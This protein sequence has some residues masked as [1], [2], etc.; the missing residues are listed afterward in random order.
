MLPR[1]VDSIPSFYIIPFRFQQKK[2]HPEKAKQSEAAK[3][4]LC[5]GGWGPSDGGKSPAKQHSAPLQAVGYAAAPGAVLG[6][7]PPK[8][9]DFPG[10][11]KRH[12]KGRKWGGN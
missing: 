12:K 5:H 10:K 6:A 8:N 11:K 3:P 2:I 4:R 9:T 1:I 7:E